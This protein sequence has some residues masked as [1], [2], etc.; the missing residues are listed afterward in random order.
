MRL[1]SVSRLSAVLFVSGMER[2]SRNLVP[3]TND[4]HYKCL[5]QD[6]Q[7]LRIFRIKK[8]INAVIL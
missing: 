6:F 4:K 2:I 5:N 7:D 3:Y 8:T 1:Y